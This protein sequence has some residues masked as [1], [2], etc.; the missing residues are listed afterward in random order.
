[1]LL[2]TELIVKAVGSSAELVGF[3]E[4]A[5]LVFF[6]GSHAGL[7]GGLLFAC[8]AEVTLET[9]LVGGDLGLAVDDLLVKLL[10]LLLEL[11]ALLAVA[12]GLAA[13]VFDFTL[14]SFELGFE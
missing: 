10:D 11:L 14:G 3:G 13:D 9:T 2:L 4:I 12:G 8:L 6:D 7:N 1:L 5:L